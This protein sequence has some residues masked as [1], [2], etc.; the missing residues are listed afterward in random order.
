MWVEELNIENVKCFEKLTLRCGDKD[1]AFKWITLLG[2]NGVGKSTALQALG[3]LLAG[4]DGANQLLTKPLGWLRD[5]GRSG[6]IS[7]KI[8]KEERD[9]GEYG[10]TKKRAVFN[11]TYFITGTEK[12]QIR[13]KIYTEP[14]IVPN[15]DRTLSWL[16]QNAF[17]AKGE[18]WFASGYGAFRRLTKRSQ[19]IVPSL[20]TPERF[21]GFLA[22][23]DEDEPLAAF[24]QW[25]VHLDYQVAKAKTEDGLAKKQQKLG[26]AAIN[27]VLPEGAKFDS[28][29]TDGKILFDVNGQ[30]VATL[31]L[32]DGYRSVLALAGDLIWRLFMSFPN[33]D[34]PM[35]EQ[36]TVLIDELD[37]HLHPVWQR[38][39]PG[40][41][42]KLFP[43][44]QFIVSTHSPFIA[45]GA[46]E[47]AKT[48]RL[49]M[50]AGKVELTH[51]QNLAFLSVEKVLESPAFEIVSRFSEEAQIKIDRYYTLKKKAKRTPQE[52]SELQMDMPILQ[53][54]IG[55]EVPKSGLEKKMDQYLDK[56]LK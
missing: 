23:F 43:N 56:M 14:A 32:S 6:K 10:A 11:F 16:R 25:F 17:Q 3:L 33:S 9:P 30:K 27:R 39:I 29:R 45:S 19:V 12:I 55:L 2:E 37:I 46:G 52:E 15:S 31:N 34:D 5:E 49:N 50:V 41:L 22:Q 28:V 47:D 21:T 36:G 13:S 1:G 24:E 20:Q 44:L 51:I 26:I 7:A 42:R 4:P 8:H 35:L 54:A 18:G 38:Q 40:M 48:Y 53:Q